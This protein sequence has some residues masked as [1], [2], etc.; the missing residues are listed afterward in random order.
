MRKA[1]EASN[2]PIALLAD[3]CGPKIRVADGFKER[4]VVVGEEVIFTGEE[5]AGPDEI[6]VSFS[7]LAEVVASGDPL[8]VED[9]R[10]CTQAIDRDGSG[11]RCL[12]LVGGTIK[13]R[14]GVN[15]PRSAVSIPP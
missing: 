5:S 3:L 12:V 9:G 10:I 1:E 4:I 2:R 15:I 11:L 7:D 13:P 14:K 8:L 6:P